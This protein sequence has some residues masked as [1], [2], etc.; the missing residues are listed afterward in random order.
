MIA[1]NLRKGLDSSIESLTSPGYQT[2]KN[3]YGALKTIERD[4]NRRAIV[5]A[6]K[7]VKGLIDFSDIFSGSQVF[8]GIV[9]MNPAVAGQGMAAKAIASL[10]KHY[11]NPNAIVKRM[12]TK[13]ENMMKSQPPAPFKSPLG[14]RPVYYSDAPASTLLTP[15]Q[16]AWKATLEKHLN[17]DKGETP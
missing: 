10:Y 16:Q 14:E 13:T 4:V 6:R 1:N 7:N 3:K 5:D 9:T 15:E 17:R 8:N 12:F 2:L 11:N